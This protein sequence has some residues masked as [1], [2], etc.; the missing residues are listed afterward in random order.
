MGKVLTKVSVA[1]GVAL[2]VQVALILNL[3]PTLD[4]VEWVGPLER[5][6]SPMAKAGAP[7]GIPLDDFYSRPHSSNATVLIVGGSDGSGTRAFVDLLGKLGVPMLVDDKVSLDVHGEP[8]LF[9]GN[10]WPPLVE[11]ILNETR[12]ASYAW[13]DLSE[14]TRRQAVDEYARLKKSYERRSKAMRK[15][16]HVPFASAVSFGFKA[17]VTMLL[18]PF[19]QQIYGS[20]KFIHVVR[21]G[22]D[23]ALSSNKSPVDKFYNTMYPTR[24]SV[25]TQVTSTHLRDVQAMQLWN[26]WNSQTYAWL[27][28]QRSVD[29]LTMRTEDLLNPTTRL[30]ALNQLAAFVGS[31]KTPVDLCCLASQAPV[32]MGRSG[33]VSEEAPTRHK[34]TMISRILQLMNGFW[35]KYGSDN[36]Q[37]RAIDNLHGTLGLLEG[38]E[39]R[40]KQ[41]QRESIDVAP[42]VHQRYGKWKGKLAQDRKFSQLIHDVGADGLR[43]FGYDPP[44]RFLDANPTPSFHCWNMGTIC[45]R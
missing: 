21:D 29:Y 37:R 38:R 34:E 30:E 18:V 6:R 43:T 8:F 44:A 1:L 3:S 40:S 24:S 41:T 10:G 22:R 32:D 5:L 31:P 33:A 23:V 26:D 4:R 2:I 36:T 12:S 17:P 9:H 27:R 39:L 11:L 15:S 35:R 13:T 42:R 7:S 19:F 20:I 25:L 45:D 16:I 14:A 28:R